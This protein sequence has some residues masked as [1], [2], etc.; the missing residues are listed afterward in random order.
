MKSV[1][2]LPANFYYLLFPI[3]GLALLVISTLIARPQSWQ[4]L[5]L[6]IFIPFLVTF[7]VSFSVSEIYLVQIVSLTGGLLFGASAAG[8]A[9]LIGI[10][11]G[12]GLRRVGI[13]YQAPNTILPRIGR[14]VGIQIIPLILT[15][16]LM[17]WQNGVHGDVSPFHLF[18]PLTI[19]ASI[20]FLLYAIDRLCLPKT[21]LPRR[22][23]LNLLIAEI[24]P[25]PFVLIIYQISE[26]IPWSILMI[27]GSVPVFIS[28]L[29]YKTLVARDQLQRHV[30][31]LSTL[32]QISRVLRSTLNLENLLSVIHQQV[33]QF[34]GV[35]NFYVALYDA[36]QG[37]ITY[38]LAVKFGKR[39]YWPPRPLQ[40][41]RLTDRVIR[42][43]KPIL[44]TPRQRDVLDKVGLPASAE[45]PEAWAGVPLIT[46]KQTIGCLAVFSELQNIGFTQADLDLLTI[47]SG[48]VSVAIENALLY[49]QTQRRAAQLETLN[50]IM[51][52]ITASLNAEEVLTQVCRS[53]MELAGGQ[54]SAV[55]LRDESANAYRLWYT[56][57][58][59]SRFIKWN[60][61]LA[62]DLGVE[63]YLQARQSRLVDDIDKADLILAYRAILTHENIRAYGDFPLITPNGQIGILSVYYDTPHPFAPEEVDLLQTLALQAA[64]AVSNARLYAVTDKA[65]A[66]RAAQL[67]ILENVGRELAAA[68]NS[69]RLF[70]MI[71]AYATKFTNS[72]WGDLSLYNPR[73][74]QLETKASQGY[75]DINNRYDL[76]SRLAGKVIL[77]R[78]AIRIENIQTEVNAGEFADRQVRSQLSI[79]LIREDRV[80]GALTLES[81]LPNAYSESDQAFI[82]QLATQAAVAVVNAELYTEIQHRLHDQ[83]ILYQLSSRLVASTEFEGILQTS[84]RALAEAVPSVSLTAYLWDESQKAYLAYDKAPTTGTL[85]CVYPQHI[86]EASL[87]S[88]QP[89]FLNT[90][91]LRIAPGDEDPAGLR[92]TC[93]DCSVTIFPIVVT[94]HRL[95][96]VLIHTPAA[97][98]LQEETLQLFYA[99]VSQI[100]ISLQN[101][102]LFQDV[103]HGRD[104][105]AAVLDSVGEGLLMIDSDGRIS[106]ANRA[107]H[108]MMGLPEEELTGKLLFGL[109]ANALLTLGYTS[110]EATN[111]VKS[112]AQGEALAA[113]KATLAITDPKP[114]RVVE[115]SGLVVWGQEGRAIGWMLVLRDITEEWQISQAREL[116]TETLIHDLRSPV[117]SVL[118]A[119]DILDSVFTDE[120]R[121]DELIDQAMRVARNSATR[122]LGLIESLLDI[123]RLKAGRMELQVLPT[124]LN[125]LIPNILG[126]LLPQAGEIGVIL[127]HDLSHNLPTIQVD[128]SKLIRVITNLI[129]NALKFTPTGGQVVVS[130]ELYPPNMVVIRV[131]DTGPGIPEEFRDKIFDRFTQ[132]PG[133]KGRRRGSGLGLTFC[134]LAVEAHGG[135]IWTEPR[136]G[137]GSVFALTIP[138]NKQIC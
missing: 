80:L 75:N 15:L 50:R 99:M 100:S 58:L 86:P 11:L 130:A 98:D 109:P 53:V 52:L 66:R 18:A 116:I 85:P 17:G 32:D 29:I 92:G 2:K 108:K 73:L 87:G 81:D 123:A 120:Q 117:S 27:L 40:P 114:E 136:T 4:S 31:E 49:E 25:L 122:V 97:Q 115:R 137:G 60:D 70:E 133:Q 57:G 36:K 71:L 68:I 8:W 30:Q 23:W 102:L 118:N 74:N 82:T 110:Q 69:P 131:S 79:P 124:K 138:I 135:K 95:G 45:T 134:R 39:N 105:M 129:D 67:E 21:T 89:A 47:L 104:R 126:D 55:Y 77:S 42:E 91:R 62:I 93:R 16:H 9:C 119:V 59:S 61:G 14:A 38:P 28:A 44:L 83:S 65:L 128:Q 106:L 35:Q 132:I 51:A 54:H 3:A 48:Q 43:G 56:F 46:S 13:G 10:L 33:T 111:L 96:M 90:E 34:V 127:R 5:A 37:L 107:I 121:S 76:N 64:I 125:E 78:Q 24:A 7:P 112:L 103:T 72:P 94:H 6:V 12:F 101:A 1:R 63:N 41:D 84:V 26:I 22:W 20:Q 88:I 19:F 113:P